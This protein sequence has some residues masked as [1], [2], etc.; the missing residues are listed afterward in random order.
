MKNDY[1][2]AAGPRHRPPFNIERHQ[3]LQV[4]GLDSYLRIL[5]AHHPD[6]SP[7]TV[8]MGIF[9]AHSHQASRHIRYI[10]YTITHKLV[11]GKSC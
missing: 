4:D 7:L 1:S 9:T 6:S 5:L 3:L 11:F 8:L 2:E 10:R